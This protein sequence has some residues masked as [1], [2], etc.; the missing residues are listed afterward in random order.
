MTRRK[1]LQNDIANIRLGQLLVCA[2]I[3]FPFPVLL[4][5]SPWFDG[6]NPENKESFIDSNLSRINI[7]NYNF[8]YS[9]RRP[10][11]AANLQHR[12]MSE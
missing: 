5:R 3:R 11:G 4:F 10:I 12:D 9:Q 2:L 7:C 1:E 8:C 6:Q